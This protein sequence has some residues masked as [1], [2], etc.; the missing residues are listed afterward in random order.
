MACIPELLAGFILEIYSIFVC[1]LFVFGFEKIGEKSSRS[2]A[3][4]NSRNH[5]KKS[6]GV[7][8]GARLGSTVFAGRRTFA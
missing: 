1:W 5:I 4:I 8:S 6:F 3:S 2:R 7:M